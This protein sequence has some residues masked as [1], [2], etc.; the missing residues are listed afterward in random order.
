VG[1]LVLAHREENTAQGMPT[2][3][4]DF[5]RL[6]LNPVGAKLQLMAAGMRPAALFENSL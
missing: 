6:I 2:G 5:D 4:L 3:T 1:E